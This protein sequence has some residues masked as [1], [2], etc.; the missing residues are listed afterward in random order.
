MAI[1]LR[2]IPQHAS[3]PRLKFFHKQADIVAPRQQLFK[4][5]PGLGVAILQNVIAHQPEAAR[6]ESAFAFGQPIAGILGF[7]AQNEFTIDQQS[8]LDRSDSSLDPRVANGKEANQRNQQ[9]TGVEA[10]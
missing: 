1:G 7:V 9:Q 2:K 3:S 8:L 5:L 6:Q 10:S 4:Q